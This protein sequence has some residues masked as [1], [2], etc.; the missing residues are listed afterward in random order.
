MLENSL[1]TPLIT[2]LDACNH[3]PRQQAW[4]PFTA[5]ANL[6][7]VQLSYCNVQHVVREVVCI[8]FVRSFH[9]KHSLYTFIQNVHSAQH[10]LKIHYPFRFGL[11]LDY[12]HCL[13]RISSVEH[14]VYFIIIIITLH[15]SLFTICGDAWP[16]SCV[17]AEACLTGWPNSRGRRDGGS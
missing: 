3:P 14:F 11:L 9:V 12:F 16:L 1:I 6:R 15:C 13:Q 17:S 2:G 5:S 10:Y 4:L 7:A 8:T